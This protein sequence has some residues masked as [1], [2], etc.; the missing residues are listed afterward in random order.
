MNLPLQ[1]TFHGVQHSD[2]IEQYVRTRAAKLDTFGRR[3]MG[4]RVAIEQ[5]HRHSQHGEQYRVR[6]DV[7]VP[8]GEVI[9]ERVPEGQ[10]AYEDVYA[11]IDAAFDD[12]VRSLQ[13]FVR[14]QRGD[15]KQH[16]RSRHAVVNKLFSYEGYG[17]LQTGEGD[18]LYFHRNAVLNGAFDRLKLGAR[19]RFVEDESES[20]PHAS[21]VE[22]I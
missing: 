22:L 2:A 17:F 14:R 20:G 18:E 9:V 16:E 11:A 1:I 4:C 15:T 12:A 6:I 10:H 3:V 21:T 19:V 7:T 5:P 8:G 13:D